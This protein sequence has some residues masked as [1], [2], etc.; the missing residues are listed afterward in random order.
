MYSSLSTTS[1]KKD[2]VSYYCSGALSGENALV[3][4]GE[5]ARWDFKNSLFVLALCTSRWGKEVDGVDLLF[6]DKFREDWERKEKSWFDSFT[7]EAWDFIVFR[8]KDPCKV[9]E[10]TNNCDVAHLA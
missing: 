3:F 1:S 9:G 4:S 2:F 8:K 10:Q 5:N 7:E 6:Q